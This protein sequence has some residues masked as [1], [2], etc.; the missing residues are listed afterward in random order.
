M[1][2]IEVGIE[3]QKRTFYA[4]RGLLS[5]YSGYFQA[6]LKG[7][8]AEAETGRFVF[9]EEDIDVVERFVLWLNSRRITDK[10]PELDFDI[11]LRLWLFAD[12]RDIPFLMNEMIDCLQRAIIERTTMPV[13]SL[14]LVYENTSPSCP[15]RRMLVESFRNLCN[16]NDFSVEAY[17]D[18]WPKQ[19]LWDLAK[20]LCTIPRP[21]L[22]SLELFEQASMCRFH[23][24]EDGVR[25]PVKPP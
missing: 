5:F 4:Y 9:A 20:A 3:E 10:T 7:S 25:C 12:R 11:I 17:I 8:W 19:A 21:D 15:L 16:P 14:H 1:A 6:A 23:V 2:T 22:S 18:M 24:H 13:E